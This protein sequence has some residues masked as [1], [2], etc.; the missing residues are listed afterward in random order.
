LLVAI[1]VFNEL[2]YVQHVLEKVR[3][4]HRE[5]LVIDD[6]STDGTA[7]MLASRSDIRLVRHAVNRGYGQSVID[8][9]TYADAHGYDWVIT[10]DCDEQHEPESIPD[11]VR[12]I[13]QDRWDIIS[14]SR[15][16][17]SRQDDDLPPGDR[18]TINA[19][20][21]SLVN[22]ALNLNITDA[23][24]GFKA[25]RVSAMMPLKL[26]EP[27]YAFPLQLWPRAALAGLRITEVPVRL[28]YKDPNRHFGGLLDDAAVRLAHYLDVFNR[29]LKTAETPA[30]PHD[31]PCC[32]PD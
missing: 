17:Q 22:N 24:C 6:G 30:A 5:I 7:E 12:A 4:F 1:P 20:I 28:I 21:T 27:G 29:E 11:F 13:E 9:F 2:Q 32:C 8:A 19:T 3:R 15:Y 18:R 25:H 26:D 16:L 10:M 23:F 31:C 14:G